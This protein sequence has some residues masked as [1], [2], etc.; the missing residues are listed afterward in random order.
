M[1]CNKIFLDIQKIAELNSNEDIIEMIS[2][3][4]EIILSSCTITI[5]AFILLTNLNY[6]EDNY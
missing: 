5:I 1:I 4:I 3:N 2:F 6:R